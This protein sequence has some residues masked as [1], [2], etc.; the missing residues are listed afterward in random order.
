MGSLDPLSFAKT[1]ALAPGHIGVV[2]LLCAIV[3][4]MSMVIW[5]LWLEIKKSTDIHDKY[6]NLV[7]QVMADQSDQA[8]EQRTAII[9]SASEQKR[10]GENIIRFE[11][12]LRE[13]TNA[14]RDCLKNGGRDGR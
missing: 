7:K 1:L 12:V 14:I 2:M 4:V 11:S 3:G 5:R 9:T 10:L 6:H 8:I 13:N